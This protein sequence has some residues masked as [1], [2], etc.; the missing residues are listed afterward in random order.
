V[1]EHRAVLRWEVLWASMY[2]LL[3]LL[4]HHGNILL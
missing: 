1:A 3:D 4:V 2:F